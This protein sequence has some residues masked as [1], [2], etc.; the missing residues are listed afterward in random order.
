M[1]L[2]GYIP[3]PEPQ[4]FRVVRENDEVVDTLVLGRFVREG[5]GHCVVDFVVRHENE[6]VTVCELMRRWGDGAVTLPDAD[7]WIND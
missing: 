1:E 6:D 5:R 7:R 2:I 4:E 3:L